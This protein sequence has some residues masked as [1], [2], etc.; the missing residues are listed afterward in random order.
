MF[1]SHPIPMPVC[2]DT[3]CANTVHGS[4]PMPARTMIAH[5]AP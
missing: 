4:R 1:V 3:P 5:P 2:S